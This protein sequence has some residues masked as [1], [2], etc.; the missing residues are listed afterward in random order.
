MTSDHRDGTETRLRELLADS[1]AQ[2]SLPAVDA[3]AVLRRSRRRRAPR[4][5]AAGG[6]FSLAAVGIV[7]AGIQGVQGFGTLSP[8]SESAGSTPNSGSDQSAS[9][10]SGAPTGAADTVNPCGGS[11]AAPTDYPG[12]SLTTEFPADASITSP[13]VQG[14]VLLTNTGD[15][16]LRATSPAVAPVTLS[17][18]GRV[19]WHTSGPMIL[20]LAEIALEPGQSY[21]WPASFIPVK[22]ADDAELDADPATLPQ[23]E[24]GLYQLSAAIDLTFAD[25]STVQLVGVPANI[26][27]R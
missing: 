16:P 7:V 15:E 6:V 11:L 9:M 18:D 27:L 13:S 12:L 22:C 2:A 1:A 8:A 25:G 24:P 5:V 10:P 3:S 14:T 21:S 19:H 26:T 4:L 20:S 17:Q 23:V